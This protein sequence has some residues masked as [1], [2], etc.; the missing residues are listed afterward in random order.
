MAELL[1]SCFEMYLCLVLLN[2]VVV[3]M[4]KSIHN[5]VISK[6]IDLFNNYH[7]SNSFFILIICPEHYASGNK[8]CKCKIEQNYPVTS[9]CYVTF[10]P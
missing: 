2:Q 1:P 3:E 8:M 9:H 4:W 10:S 5:I 7:E 6:T